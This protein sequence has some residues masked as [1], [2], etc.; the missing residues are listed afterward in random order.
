MRETS[1]HGHRTHAWLACSAGRGHSAALTPSILRPPN[2]PL[3]KRLIVCCDGT[4]NEIEE[5]GSNVL[6]LFKCLELDDEQVGYYDPGVGTISDGRAW[7]RMRTQVR[8]VFGLATGAGLDD[9]VL[10]AYRFLCRHYEDGDELYFFGFS[11]GAYTVR[12]LAGLLHMV[13]LCRQ[14]NENLLPYALTA[15]KRASD[16]DDFAHAW[17]FEEMMRT[18]RVTIRFM[19]CWDTVASVIVPRP[20]RLFLPA[21]DAALPYT[22][23]NPSVRVFRHAVALDERRRLF[24]LMRWREGQLFKWNPFQADADARPQD[25]EQVWFAGVHADIGGGYPEPESGPAKF[26]LAWML[27]EAGLHGLRFRDRMVARLVEGKN[28]ANSRRQYAAPDAT[29]PLH[30]S[31]NWAWR[32]LEWLPK[33]ARWKEW[34]GRR[35]FLGLYL[36]RA[37]PRV[38][39]EGAVLHPSVAERMAADGTGYEPVNVDP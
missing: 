18:R 7:S 33:R 22:C 6:K 3:T 39:G 4:G 32:I 2:A 8:G 9:N 25:C 38:P 26:P 10:D 16:T 17:R 28:P 21:L 30:D 24:R 35:T 12:V 11:R 29:A 1:H 13:G 5:Q 37:E 31:M 36:P 20:D 19:G 34:P 23:S 15:Y 14:E 27:E